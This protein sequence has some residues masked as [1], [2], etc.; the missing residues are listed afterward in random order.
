MVVD[1]SHARLMLV[2]LPFS[3][4]AFFV[5]S[6]TASSCLL[7]ISNLETLAKRVGVYADHLVFAWV[8]HYLLC[9]EELLTR[10][11]PSFSWGI[12]SYVTGLDQSHVSEI[13]DGL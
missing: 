5:F 11:F 8:T 10:I 6:G 13:F 2:N 1:I 12:F 9:R 7:R 3:F 4:I